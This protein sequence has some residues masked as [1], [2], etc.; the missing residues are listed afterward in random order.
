MA[1]FQNKPLIKIAICPECDCE[2]TVHSKIIPGK[3]IECTACGTESECITTSPLQF[4][5][6]EEEK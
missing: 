3:I 2:I 1:D 4:A 6:L 5:P